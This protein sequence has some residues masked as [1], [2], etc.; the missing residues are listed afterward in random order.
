MLASRRNGGEAWPRAGRVGACAA[1]R[2]SV[3]CDDDDGDGGDGGGGSDGDGGGGEE[4]R[5]MPTCSCRAASRRER[6]TSHKAIATYDALVVSRV[7]SATPVSERSLS[8]LGA[9]CPRYMAMR[10]PADLVT[11]ARAYF[12]VDRR[13]VATPARPRTR[14]SPRAGQRGTHPL[15]ERSLD[16]IASW[17]E[18]RKTL[19]RTKSRKGKVGSTRRRSLI[20]VYAKGMTYRP[21]QE[22]QWED[23][24]GDFARSATL[25]P[26]GIGRRG[27]RHAARSGRTQ[28]RCVPRLSARRFSR[29]ESVLGFPRER[30]RRSRHLLS[31][32]RR[33]RGTRISDSSNSRSRAHFSSRSGR[34]RESAAIDRIGVSWKILAKEIVKFS[35]WKSANLCARSWSNRSFASYLSSRV[36]GISSTRFSGLRQETARRLKKCGTTTESSPGVYTS[37]CPSTP[38]RGYVN[39]A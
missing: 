2:G 27:A 1:L 37:R 13:V 29:S 10:R 5:P 30:E 25:T 20:R 33:W 35:S 12:I 18:P 26:G 17:R 19:A 23:H 7:V 22:R 21:S 9:R 14:G 16:F 39:G 38:W 36:R 4:S 28:E 3:W 15:D 31:S 8:V 24:S 11:I 32:G 34:F 6:S